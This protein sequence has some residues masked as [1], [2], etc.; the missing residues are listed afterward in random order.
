MKNLGICLGSSNISMVILE[1]ING[2][3]KELENK[4]LPHDGNPKEVV[5]ELMNDDILKNVDNVIFTGRQM[6]GFVKTS[7]ISE[8][9]AIEVAYKYSEVKEHNVQVVVSAGGEMLVVYKLDQ[10]GKVVDLYSGNKCA[11]GTGEFFLQQLKRMDTEVE[12]AIQMADKDNPYKVSGRCSVFCKSDCTHALNKGS[13]KEKII[14]GL[15]EMMA[16]KVLELIKATKT[17][18]IMVIGGLS[19]NTTMLHYLEKDIEKIFVPKN[20]TYFEAYG[21]ALWGFENKCAKVEKFSDVFEENATSFTKLPPLSNYTD[22]VEFKTIEMSKAI[23]GQRSILGIDVGSTT[24]KAVLLSTEDNKVTA[25]I[26]LRTNGDPVGAARECY[27]AILEE[28][29]VPVN[30]V[31]IGV[32]GSGRSVVGLHAMTDGVINEIIAHATAAAFFDKEVDTIF[33][34]GGQD[35]KYTYLT[36]GAAS[37]YA[38]NEACSAG[39]GSFLE[40]SA[41]ESLGVETKEIGDYAMRG[42]NPPNFSEQCSA[43]I[44]SDIKRAIQEGMSK[45]EITAGLVYSICLNYINRVKGNRSVGKKIFMQGGVCYNKS[46]PVAMAALTGKKIIVPPEPGLMGAFGVALD[47]KNKINLGLLEEQI[48]DLNELKERGAKYLDPF[49]CPGGKE[50]C[51]L[52]CK[53]NRIEMNGK[54][55]PFG[56]A[57]NK[58]TSHKSTETQIDKNDFD[59]VAIREKLVFDK[60]G[61]NFLKEPVQRTNKTIGIN[62]SLLVNS[63]FPLYYNFF[64]S[65]G[66]DVILS[67][68]VEREG[69]DRKGAPFCYPV[70]I[71]HGMM[72]NLVRK[73]LDYYFLPHVESLPVKE[74]GVSVTCPF[75]QSEAF[76][77]KS[78]FNELTDEKLIT[79]H[80]EFSK[81][82]DKEIKKFIGIG[83]KLGF[84]EDKINW[85]FGKAVKAQQSY[86]EEC[87]KIGKEV[88]DLIENSDDKYGVVVF[89]R[90]YNAFARVANMGIPSKFASKGRYTIP[91]DFLPYKEEELDENSNMYWAMG[92]IILKGAQIVQKSDK[93]FGAFISNF[94]CGPDSFVIGDFRKIMGEKPSLTLELDSHTADAGVDTRIEAFLDIVKSYCELKVEGAKNPEDY[95]LAKTVYE[96][97][98][99]YVID[100]H[101]TKRDLRDKKVKIVVPAMG[102]I[103]NR[104]VAA[105]MQYRGVNAIAM[106]EPMEEELSQGKNVSLCKECMPLMLT[107]GTLLKYL[108]ERENKDEVVLYFM[109][110]T[111]GPCRFGQYNTF[112]KTL[113]EKEKIKDVA[114]LS[115]SSDN[116]YAGLGKR[117]TIRTWQG[118][119]ADEV[120][121]E[122]YSNLLVLA[123][124][125]DKAMAIYDKAV[126]KVVESLSKDSW[127]QVRKVMAKAVKELSQIETKYH[128]KD[129]KKVALVGEIYVRR[130][131]FSKRDLIEK[132]A[133]RDVVVKISP[134]LEWIHYCDYLIKNKV[135]SSVTDRDKYQAIVVGWFKNYY[136]KAIKNIFGKLDFYEP[137][138]IDVKEVM[139]CSEGLISEKFTGEAILTVG[140]SI[141]E[142]ADK[143]AGVIN[144]GPF[145]C[146][147]S[148]IAEAVLNE[149][150]E[151]RKLEISKDKPHVQRVLSEFENLP[152]MTIEVDGSPF[153]QLVEAKLESFMLQ[154]D[155]VHNEM[156]KD[157]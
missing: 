43:F 136:E 114:V 80:F 60:Y 52:K 82:Y 29:K 38:M 35:A 154:V 68:K 76:Y 138:I 20:S 73:N 148:R 53:I 144:I 57:C 61:V 113:I 4:V 42:L 69:I 120:L 79:E 90:P 56:G 18:E 92:R 7:S 143:V 94:S 75:V 112:M 32:T 41:Y 24:T 103:G 28:S 155:R 139:E 132:M 124:D 81:G 77:L 72:E 131:S 99:L 74:G 10:K 65:L 125:K 135:F 1:N 110:E 21:A 121:E 34:I 129:A 5:R 91:V 89:G 151:E 71:A 119:V 152:F 40:E 26:Y 147:P 67:E 16:G 8:P 98:K 50:K 108:K 128:I 145:G 153:S 19:K 93:L 62:N 101:G 51:D 30:V 122:I 116:S 59:Y 47:I 133:E 66:L 104:F 107:T 86:H 54:V 146:M 37:D 137:H 48:F 14:A 141:H 95:R 106:P 55:Y 117:F 70:E 39:T 127:N 102:K 36:N 64:N 111:S 2:E 58:Y 33:E 87:Q 97:G 23:E 150:L 46:I 15:C 88:L 142:I 105:A 9:E 17:N 6:R 3:I 22:M 118:I 109:P 130:D 12:D 149:K 123:K 140:A 156:K 96:D 115:L 134:A 11:S 100:S 126:D 85:A 49:V 13:G 63:L 45:E 44:S 84:T 25:S 31:G 27:K 157:A 83:K 78:A